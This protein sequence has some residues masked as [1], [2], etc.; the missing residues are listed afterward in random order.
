[1]ENQLLDSPEFDPHD[2]DN[3]D[4]HVGLRV[5]SFCM[6]IAGLIIYMSVSGEKKRK[7]ACTWALIG[8]GVGLV[9]RILSSATGGGF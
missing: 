1:M 5:L 7:Q 8:M 4:L 9:L 2:P 6:P 3:E